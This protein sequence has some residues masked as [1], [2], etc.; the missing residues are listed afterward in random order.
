M[1]IKLTILVAL[2]SLATACA[3]S[4]PRKPTPEAA[5]QIL[6]LRGYEFNGKAFHAAI[7]ASDLTAVT[8]FMD[9]GI[10]I[11]EQV[12]PDGD[13]A[14]ILAASLGETDIVKALLKR[15]ADPNIVDKGGY[16]ALFRALAGRHN[17]IADLLLPLPNLN[18]NARGLNKVTA[19]ITY[20]SRDREDVVKNLIDRGADVT[21]QDGDGDTALH[22]TVQNGN[23]ALTNLLLAKGAP[24]NVKNKVGGTPLMWAAATGNEELAKLLLEHGADPSI[25]DEDGVT[26]LGWATKNKRENVIALL[27]GK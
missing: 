16:T 1:K 12:E 22:L 14:L 19:L 13:T 10:N 9:A 7:Q 15:Q 24:V 27:K 2:L 26:A 5:Q 3:S 18:L 6:K 8:A 23:V 17:D 25:K 4:G 11:N 20:A 21:L